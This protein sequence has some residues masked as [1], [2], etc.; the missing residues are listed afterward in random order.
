MVPNDRRLVSLVMH[1]AS[2]ME[3]EAELVRE[4]VRHADR[5]C[6]KELEQVGINSVILQPG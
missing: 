1:F 3:R 2:T 6:Q 5:E 4:G